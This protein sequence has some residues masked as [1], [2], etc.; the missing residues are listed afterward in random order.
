MISPSNI[1]AEALILYVSPEPVRRYGQ[2]LV[3]VIA[4]PSEVPSW[5][6]ERRTVPSDLQRLMV[7][8][9]IA[10]FTTSGFEKVEVTSVPSSSPPV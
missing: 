2:P 1:V 6:P 3:D 4:E 5:R 10:F 8:L 7:Q 9:L